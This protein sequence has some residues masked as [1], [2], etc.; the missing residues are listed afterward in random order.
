MTNESLWFHCGETN[1]LFR[2]K[3]KPTGLNPWV[4]RYGC[5]LPLRS[6]HGVICFEKSQLVLK[7]TDITMRR[8]EGL[9]SVLLVYEVKNTK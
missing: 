6:K 2:R 8:G 7:K 9:N 3:L 4:L 1:L 5:D